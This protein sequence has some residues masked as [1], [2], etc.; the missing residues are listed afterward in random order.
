MN[1]LISVIVPVYNVEIYLKDCLNSLLNQT[2]GNFEIIL[3][4]DGS[5]DNSLKI[6]K[7][8][9]ENYKNIRLFH[10][11]N[12]GV[13][14]TR[15]FGIDVSNGKYIVFV[16]SDDTVSKYYL[17]FL[18]KA[19]K[20]NDKYGLA[21]CDFSKDNLEN[22]F[23]ESIIEEKTILESKSLFNKILDDNEEFDG[24]LWNK[25]FISEILK[26]NNI[27][28][29]KEIKIWE[30]MYFVLTYLKYIDKIIVIKEKLYLY[31][32]RINSAVH[33]NDKDILINKIKA[34]KLFSQLD[35]E[36][37]KFNILVKQHYLRCLI[38]LFY[39]YGIHIDK[40]T[41]EDY[42]T[43]KYLVDWKLKIKYYVGYIKW[44]L[45]K[46]LESVKLK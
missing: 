10:H 1:D 45:I 20:Q 23:D 5:T 24:F 46:K 16:D 40:N 21:I 28:F 27:R 11:E 8:F 9:K 33:S 3:I 25:I 15:N 39:N 38:N 14:E 35:S 2:Y 4:D 30:D 6:C 17:E 13:S 43:K 19:I 31:R 36:N 37:E 26:H 32:Q 29:P 34:T 44:N 7:K 41:I 18:Y 12:R 22:N 42:F